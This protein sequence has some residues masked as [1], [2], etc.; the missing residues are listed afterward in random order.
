MHVATKVTPKTPK[1]QDQN[2]RECDEY[3]AHLGNDVA[4]AEA[5]PTVWIREGVD[6]P[7]DDTAQYLK[8]KHEEQKRKVSVVSDIS[9][10]REN[11]ITNERHN[12]VQQSYKNGLGLKF[13]SFSEC[14]QK[15]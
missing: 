2:H 5:D 4:T 7:R 10:K 1:T 15:R 6:H 3:S 14:P 9:F 11:Q 8:Q 12:N 13:T